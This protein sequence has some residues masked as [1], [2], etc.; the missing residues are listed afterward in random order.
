MTVQQMNFDFSTDATH[1]LKTDLWF[2]W[3]FN[4]LYITISMRII[5]YPQNSNQMLVAAAKQAFGS[6]FIDSGFTLLT[7]RIH[8]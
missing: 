5:L 7:E 1:I 8:E 4:S 6:Y 3:D 2:I